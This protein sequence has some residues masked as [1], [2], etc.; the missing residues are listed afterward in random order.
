MSALAICCISS[1][2]ISAILVALGLSRSSAFSGSCFFEDVFPK[3]SFSDLAVAFIASSAKG[4]LAVSDDP[5][6]R[7]VVIVFELDHTIPP[8]RGWL[9]GNVFCREFASSPFADGAVG[10]SSVRYAQL[11]SLAIGRSL[12]GEHVFRQCRSMVIS[13]EDG[14]KELRRRILAARLH[15]GVELEEMEGWFFL[16]HPASMMARSCWR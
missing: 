1:E 16:L 12:T 3:F 14:A 5:F 10:K 6:W 7:S 11:L 15:H 13:L 9:L 8:P 2:R 4:L